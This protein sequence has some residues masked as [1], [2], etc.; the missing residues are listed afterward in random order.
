MK[1]TFMA[2]YYVSQ[3]KRF[4]FFSHLSLKPSLGEGESLEGHGPGSLAY[5]EGNN[6]TLFQTKRMRRPTT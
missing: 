5:A 3:S 1:L 6:E 2:P 4:P